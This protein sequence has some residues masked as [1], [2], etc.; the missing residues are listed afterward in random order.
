MQNLLYST[1]HSLLLKFDPEFSHRILHHFLKFHPYLL[2]PINLKKLFSQTDIDLTTKI[3]KTT[4]AHPIGFAAGFDKYGDIAHQLL[5]FGTSFVEV[6]SLTLKAQNGNNKP[7][8]FRIKEHYSLLNRFGFNNPGI[9]S[10]LD[11]LDSNLYKK[12]K[13]ITPISIGKNKSTLFE[14]LVQEYLFVFEIIKKQTNILPYIPYIVINISSPNTPNLRDLQNDNI[15]SKILPKIIKYSPKPIYI[16]ISPDLDNL[17]YQKLLNILLEED[18]AGI[19][20]T[21]TTSSDKLKSSMYLSQIINS[22]QTNGGVSGAILTQISREKL[23]IAYKLCQQK[24][25]APQLIASGGISSKK[26]AW[27]R[28]LLGADIIQVYTGFIFEGPFFIQDSLQYIIQKM[29]EYKIKT[30]NTLRTNR[31]EILKLELEKIKSKKI[32]FL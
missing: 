25:K 31:S 7:R 20:L 28:M 17:K 14:D 22:D 13:S 8:L 10:G 11:A 1:I 3:Q 18:I 29:Q 21:N 26:E 16:K 4:I 2:P 19:I 24:N 32:K 12:Q 23:L 15:L 5:R 6:G 30:I 9:L 27:I